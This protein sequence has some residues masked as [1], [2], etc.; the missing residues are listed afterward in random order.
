MLTK[1]DEQAAIVFPPDIVEGFLVHTRD[2]ATQ[3]YGDSIELVYGSL[4]ANQ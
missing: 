1:M 2:F 4:S 3:L